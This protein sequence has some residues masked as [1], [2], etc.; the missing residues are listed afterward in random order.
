M[1]IR[2]LTPFALLGLFAA[3][4]AQAVIIDTFNGAGPGASST[5]TTP[6]ANDTFTNTTD[7]LGG[8]REVNITAFAPGPNGT[9]VSV[10][11][12]A[13]AGQLAVS[14][15]SGYTSTSVLTWDNAGAGLGGQDLTAGG[16]TAL[17]LNITNIDVGNVT[18]TFDIYDAPNSLQA[19]LALGGLNVGTHYFD[20]SNFTGSQGALSSATKITLT[21]AATTPSADLSLDLV[22]TTLPPPPTTVPEPAT[23]S[24]LGA[25]LLGLLARKK[26]SA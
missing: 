25:G 2:K 10:N 3:G 11:D 15:N 21:I 22:Q 9:T 6:L 14:N 16:A 17:Q 12:V 18:L 13:S 20:F 1:F 4:S 7:A 5:Y 26:K 24:L 19:T 23:L 8:W